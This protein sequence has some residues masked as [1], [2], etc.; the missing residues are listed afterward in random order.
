MNKKVIAALVAVVLITGIAALPHA[1]YAQS[2]TYQ[3]ALSN[4]NAAKQNLQTE[5]ENLQG[6]AQKIKSLSEEVRKEISQMKKNGTEIPENAREDLKKLE[7]IRT[8]EHKA[9]LIRKARGEYAKNILPKIES[10]R[11]EI[12][13]KKNNGATNEQIKPLT[14]KLR[15]MLRDF[16]LVAPLSPERMLKSSDK[17][18]KRAES[19]KNNGKEKEA[20][21]I[22]DR[23]TKS[24]NKTAKA[25]KEREEKADKLIELL[26]KV[27]G[28][29][30]NG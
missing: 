24:Y 9:L 5:T 27:K 26:N 11:K 3:E 28:E 19:L 10:L 29:L 14:E 21:R 20:I 25:L 7:K 15:N 4:F 13:E 12:K 18:L 1:T 23:A 22:L 2:G 8:M 30:G 17:I 6:K 16:R